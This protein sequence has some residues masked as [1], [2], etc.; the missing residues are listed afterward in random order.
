MGQEG[1]GWA[2]A[3]LTD[4]E[5]AAV[6]VDEE[7]EIEWASPAARRLL[8]AGY[9]SLPA[10]VDVDDAPALAGYLRYLADGRR[11]AARFS[12]AVP[13]EESSPRRVEIVGRDLRSNPEV[14]GIVLALHDVTAWA[15]REAAL[16]GQIAV[17]DLTGLDNRTAM[18][19]RVHQAARSAA[20]SGPG[21]AVLYLDLD[22]FKLVND[23]LGH[24][25][26]DEVLKAIAHRVQQEVG[27]DGSVARIG[28][29]EFVVLVDRTTKLGAGHLADRLLHLVSY[30]IE[31]EGHSVTVTVSIGI[32]LASGES[33]DSVLRK[34]DI[35]MYRS[36]EYGR[37]C[38]T[39]HDEE[40]EDWGRGRKMQALD[41][42]AQVERLR[43][44]NRAL[45]E[46]ATTDQRTGL[47]NHV[48]FE[49][50]HAEL[51]A[52]FTN[53]R[54]GYSLLLVDIDEFHAYN[55]RYRYLAGHRTLRQV[56][57]AIREAVR[58]DDRVYRYGGEEFTVLAP[59]TGL[60]DAASLAERIRARVQALRIEHLAGAAGV[61]TVSIGVATADR[62][63]AQ[64]PSMLVEA[65]NV[66][67]L[68]AKDRGRNT[69]SPR[70]DPVGLT[71]S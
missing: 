36:K 57:A 67:L 5:V 63:S 40:T 43:R 61:V 54:G 7:H 48:L 18:V 23:R 4:A 62:T 33:V 28:G 26:G 69:V 8:G 51:H 20:V 21:P 50:D 17:D 70:I 56:A 38:W 31:V 3:V 46:A 42:E 32:A 53:G 45:A 58:R 47:A 10:L 55:A 25:L 41:L 65:A 2:R 22:R 37:G 14:G 71:R 6:L 60:E 15:E 59:G 52:Q 9:G 49:R 13:V 64:D 35:A 12:C 11:S 39:I 30:P 19:D 16:Q 29:D 27:D 66:Q 34:A 1:L 68:R 24:H 44:E